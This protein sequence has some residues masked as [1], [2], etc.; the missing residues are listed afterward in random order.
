MSILLVVG[1][2]LALI[3]GAELMVRGA[4]GIAAALGIS[5]LIVGLTVVAFG[6][7]APEL[8]VAVTAGATGNAAVTLGNVVGSNVFNVLAILG[9]SAL[10]APL[11]VSHQLVRLDV[12]VMIAASLAALAVAADGSIGL[13]DGII[14]LAAFAVYTVVLILIARRQ[15][16]SQAGLGARGGAA[17]SPGPVAD[18]A[19]AGATHSADEEAA[20]G[21]AARP[22]PRWLVNLLMVA[23]GLG[24]LV[25]G[26]QW[27][28]RGAADI[29]T[30]LGMSEFVIG[31]VIVATGTSM[32]ELVTS[33]VAGLRGNRDIA[34]GNVVGSNI[35]NALIVLG[36]G[37]VAD[38]AAGGGGAAAAGLPGLTVEPA[39]LR[40]D[41]IVM[42]VVALGC[43]P[44][45]FT[46][47]RIDRWEGGLFLA[48]YAAYLAY[49]LGVATRG[50]TIGLAFAAPLTLVTVAVIAVGQLRR[51]GRRG[52]A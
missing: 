5:P 25:A 17:E 28:V 50:L 39:V 43:L 13:I 6:T 31:V 48:Y 38:G 49:L 18:T 19:P 4:S 46:G 45:F 3:V 40:F 23:V 47:F 42:V 37:A 26:S 24:L 21:S 30:A 12:P 52:R 27:L 33:V 2:L 32:P 1:G 16:R 11:A 14:L 29:A 20:A 41:M 15:A 7:S 35:F 22:R 34:V 36:G 8:A 10:I 9:I 51:R 44:I